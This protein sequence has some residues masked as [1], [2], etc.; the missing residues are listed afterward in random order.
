MKKK[1]YEQIKKKLSKKIDS[2]LTS[3]LPKKWERIGDVLTLVLPKIYNDY[4][5]L[6]GETYAE[7]LKCKTVQ[8]YLGEI[9]GVFRTP[10]VEIIYGSRNTETVHKENNIKYKLDPAKIMFSSGN[11][12]ERKRMA[13]ISNKH[14][15]V[16]DMFA[17]IGYFT[18]PI[19]VYSKPKKIFSCEINP[20]SYGYLCDNIILNDVRKIVKP[21][22]GDN[23]KTAPENSADRIIMGYLKKTELYLERAFKCL[24]NGKGKV[25]Y[26]D[27][28]PDNSIPDNALNIVEKIGKKN[29]KKII[30]LDYKIVK[31][32][33]PGISH[34]VLD[35]EIV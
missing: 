16:V 17:G 21:L 26:H 1:P 10:K 29:H 31:S 28:C 4:K 25:H 15:V 7:V 35:L 18:I 8:N 2:N 13:N 11:M 5:F 9:S 27:T 19:A 6:I 23:K 20:I 14:E 24:K 32:Y 33:A 30:L 3:Y 34:I 12:S 22:L